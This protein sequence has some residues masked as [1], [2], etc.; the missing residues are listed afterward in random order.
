MSEGVSGK[1]LAGLI[2]ILSFSQAPMYELL[3]K[4]YGSLILIFDAMLSSSYK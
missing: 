4:Q 3:S 2:F 1:A